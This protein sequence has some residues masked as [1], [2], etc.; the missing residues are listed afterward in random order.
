M[1][2]VAALRQ[3]IEIS[4]VSPGLRPYAEALAACEAE[5][6][7]L[8]SQIKPADTVELADDF[9]MHALNAIIL[10]HYSNHSKVPIDPSAAAE[11]AYALA[12]AMMAER[13]KGVVPNGIPAAIPTPQAA[14]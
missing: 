9:A 11:Q 6:G 10:S 7:M 3:L 2:D 4:E 12:R 13:R 14:G 5:I 8:Q 1:I